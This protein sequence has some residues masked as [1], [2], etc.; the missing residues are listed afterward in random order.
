[1]G[2]SITSLF[3]V[4][5]LY[6]NE[7]IYRTLQVGNAGGVRS[8]VSDKG[9]VRRLV[10][11]TSVPTAR[12]RSENPYYDRIEG[13]VLVYTGAGREGDQLMSGPNA[14]ILQQPDDRFPIYGFMLIESRRKQQ[15]GAKRWSFLGL[16]E[17]LRFYQEQQ[18][19]SKGKSRLAWIF[20]L[21]V[22]TDLTSVA[23]DEDVQ[24]M[25]A[26][27]D[28]SRTSG[29]ISSDDRLVLNPTPSESDQDRAEVEAIRARLLAYEPRTFELLL[30]SLLIQ[31]GFERVTVTK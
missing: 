8:S 29:S 26:I 6:S 10:V 7:E 27:L 13:E 15:A 5:K 24:L 21:R 14:R 22:C 3:E 2:Q 4:G 16:L 19:D 1:M 31:S 18:F 17:F 30:Q 23:V 12:Q 28:R 11:M 9:I 20:E 25:Q